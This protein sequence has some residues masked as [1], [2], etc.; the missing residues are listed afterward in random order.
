MLIRLSL[1]LMEKNHNSS[2]V[3][4]SRVASRVE[5]DNSNKKGLISSKEAHLAPSSPNHPNR[6]RATPLNQNKNKGINDKGF[7]RKGS[8]FFDSR[9]IIRF[10]KINKE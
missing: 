2:P 4:N 1:L 6:M 3:H 5:T 8:P 7:T 10:A 9:I